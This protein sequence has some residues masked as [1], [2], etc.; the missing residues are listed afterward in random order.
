MQRSLQ[1]HRA[2][3]CN[4]PLSQERTEG[5]ETK[6]EQE[7]RRPEDGTPS[8]PFDISS[9]RQQ[10]AGSAKSSAHSHNGHQAEVEEWCYTERGEQTSTHRTK[11]PPTTK[12][13]MER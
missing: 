11:Q 6:Q 4:G 8:P 7:P 9:S 1:V 10:P 3:V 13:G 12:R 5:H 2:P